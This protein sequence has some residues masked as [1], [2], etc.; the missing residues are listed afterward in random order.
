MSHHAIQRRFNPSRVTRQHTKDELMQT[1][2]KSLSRR[3]AAGFGAI[4][5]GL[6]GALGGGMAASAALIDGPNLDGDSGS[7]IVHKYEEPAEA[8]GLPNDGTAQDMTGYTP[9]NGVEFTVQ[10]VT[11]IDLTT[12]QGWDMTEGLTAAAVMADPVA[13]P[14]GAAATGVTGAGA[15]AAGTATFA[16]LPVGLYLVT[17][18]NVGDNPIAIKAQP[19]LVSVPLPTG[20]NQWIY[21][22]NVYPKNAVTTIDKVVDDAAALGLGDVVDWTITSEVPYLAEGDTFDLFSITDALDSRL[23]FA[24]ASLTLTDATDTPVA[25]VG[26]DFDLVLPPVGSSGLISLTFTPDGLEKLDGAQGGT[27]T[28]EVGTTILSIG[29]GTIENE[30]TFFINEFEGTA[31]A[32]TNWGA[33]QILKYA[34]NGEETDYLQGAQFQV[35]S[36]LAD[37]NA[38]TNPVS[39]SGTSTFSTDADGEIIL[40]GLKAGDYWL[41]ETQPPVGYTTGDAGP[42]A[43]TVTAGS[44]EQAV[45]VEVE[46]VQKPSVDLPL[47]GASGVLLLTLG[48]AGLL[49][50]AGGTALVNHRRKT[51][52]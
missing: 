15:E 14:L 21:D 30:A 22:V 33:V 31:D 36:T 1:Q 5:L 45:L 26:T 50:I 9:L 11:S 35:F 6:I 48:G 19:F 52:R 12:Y 7:I 42:I 25:L 46:N 8:T 28:V 10:Q 49:S 2:R 23:G 16:D 44:L 38:L 18:T 32:V 29:D 4:T 47:T 24:T 17:E 40:S 51:I 20:D 13:Y 39:I 3:I 37:A 27:L 43:V 34:M 41:V